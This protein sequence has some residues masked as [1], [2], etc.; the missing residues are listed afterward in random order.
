MAFFKWKNDYCVEIVKINDQH[1][2]LVGFL[3]DLFEAM[4]SGK[5]KTIPWTLL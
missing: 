4:K 3:N 1:K 5:G 2:A